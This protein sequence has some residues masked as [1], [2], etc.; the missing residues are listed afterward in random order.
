MILLNKNSTSK[1]VLTLSE[2]VT[3]ASPVYFL[4]EIISDDTLKSVFFT[5]EDF[6]TNVCRYNEFEITL[7]SGTPDPTIGIIDLELNGYYKYNIYQQADQFNLDPNQTGGIIENGKVY[8]KG[9]LKPST[10]SYTDNN[11]N[12]YISYE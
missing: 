11:N 10:T 6:S 5:A 4:F 3:I 7:T 2:S 12:T 1:V 9:E 8:V